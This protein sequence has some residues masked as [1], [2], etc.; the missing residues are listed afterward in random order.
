[1]RKV[2]TVFLLGLFAAGLVFAQGTLLVNGD[3]ETM[4][5]NFWNSI[6]SGAT[7]TWSANGY[8][9]SLRSFEIEKTAATTDIVGW[10]SDNNAQLYWNHAEAD[11]IYNLSFYVKTVGVNT[12]PATD[13]EKIGV[14]YEF[15]AGGTSIGEKIIY[16]DQ[17]NADMDWT[18]FTDG[19][20]PTAGSKP[21]EIY[22][23]LF[24]GKN[25]TGTVYFDNVSYGTDP[26]SGGVFNGNAE[27][28][29][30]W[31]EWHSGDNPL[32]YSNLDD[33][34]A[35]SGTY[36]A[37]LRERDDDSDE[38]VF[39]SEPVA[40][41]PGKWYQISVWARWDSINTNPNY[42][43]SNIVKEN[44]SDRLG[45][46]F[47]FHKTSLKGNWDLT[48]GDQ[49]FYFDQ[50]DSTS[51]GWV[52]YKVIAQSPDDAVGLSCRARFNS[53]PEGYCWYD[54]FAIEEV[55]FDPNLLVNGDLETMQPNFWNSI[56]SGATMTWSANGY[57]GS[58]RSFEI[59]KTAATTDIVGWKSDN[60]AQLYWN[61]AE[62]DAIY[63]LSFYVKTVGVNTSPATDDEKIGV[64]YEFFAGGTSIGEKIIYIDQTNA[65]MDWTEFTDGVAP[66]AGSKPD[67]IYVTLFMGKNATGTVYFDNVSYGTDPW[68]GGVFNGNAEI[69]KGWM[70]WHSGDN[71][72]NY[73]NLDDTYAHSGT[74]SALLRER[75]D[76]SDEMVFYSEPVAAEPGKWYQ[77][78][79]WARWDSINTNP[80]YAP[81][82]IVKENISD[83]LGMCFFFHKTSLKGNWD[84]T[85][86]D[87]FF[88]FDQR[89]STSDGWV[90]YRV[91]AQAPD[92]AVG[93]SSR[94][95]FNPFPE[96]YCWYDDFS[97]RK[98]KVVD[99]TSPVEDLNRG[100]N[101]VPEK[102]NL[103]QNYPNPFNPTTKIGYMIQKSG[104]VELTVYNIMGKKVRTLV[105]NIQSAGSYLIQWDGCDDNGNIVNS[106]VY[107]YQLRT[108]NNTITKRMT[109][110][111]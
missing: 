19:V 56:G 48:G 92:D 85:G 6:G 106:G 91:V 86:G 101:Q 102:F 100:R 94:A 21:D 2:L 57:D 65:D 68:S 93:I 61:H 59:E 22:V 71:P 103:G 107:F 38:M 110:M 23:T 82:N 62:A 63:N 8:D 11:A 12:S 39:Y 16:I 77:I 95:R 28:P 74:Y 47:F 26:W 41:E 4:Q 64:K 10:K 87:Q 104:M 88:Y 80:N 1:M 75:D 66:T 89:D 76:D 81:S 69:P 33:T 3:L 44:I 45:M 105:N 20:A 50:R 109:F 90:Q 58:L 30:G 24:M 99:T 42:A 5:P 53:F 98:V 29:K 67:E 37:L 60:N 96:G 34:Y 49:F 79:V 40:A 84:L 9:G 111:K 25:A 46:C 7:M 43:P 17:T 31:M 78:S 83:R 13:D 36:S 32:N 52:Q 73:S 70:E 51:D 108:E 18:E 14:K 97:I 27:I 55:E 35:H 54:D 72:L 15:F